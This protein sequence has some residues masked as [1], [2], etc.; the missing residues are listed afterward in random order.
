MIGG[1]CQPGQRLPQRQELTAKTA[2]QVGMLQD[3]TISYTNPW[4]SVARTCIAGAAIHR[5]A[6]RFYHSRKN[7]LCEYAA[8]AAAAAAAVDAASEDY[9]A[10][11]YPDE[12]ESC[13]SRDE[14]NESFA[15]HNSADELVAEQAG[16]AHDS[17]ITCYKPQLRPRAGHTGVADDVE[18]EEFDVDEYE[19]SG[20]EEQLQ[21]WYNSGAAWRAILA[22]ECGML[23]QDSEGMADDV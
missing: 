11:D 9:Y 19:S 4:Y 22:K 3:R 7:S 18:S 21:G 5:L 23:Q 16:N 13:H 12:A 14:D 15:E 1:Q 10:N 17:L 20:D 8:A 2:T 6:E